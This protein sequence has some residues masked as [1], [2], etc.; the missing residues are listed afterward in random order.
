VDPPSRFAK[1]QGAGNRDW[2][3]EEL[4]FPVPDG[5]RVKQLY[6]TAN[7]ASNDGDVF[8][9]AL[10]ARADQAWTT[11]GNLFLVRERIYGANGQPYMQG[12][13]GEQKISFFLDNSDLPWIGIEAELETDPA[14]IEQWR[15]DTWSALYNAAQTAYYAEQQDIA[16]KIAALEDRLA[17]VDTLTLRRE[18]SE[19]V[20]KGVLKFI[21]GPSFDLMEPVVQFMFE[22][23]GLDAKHG[24]VF[25]GSKLPLVQGIGGGTVDP[26]FAF[27][28]IRHHEEMVRF[29]NQAIEWENVVTFLYSYFWDI[30]DSW[31][32]IRQLRHV[33]ATRQAFL[34]AGS[35][36]VVLTVRKGWEDKWMTFVQSGIIDADLAVPSTGPYLSIAQEIAA[37]DDRNYPGIP[38]ANPAR[39]AERLQDANYTISSAKINPGAGPITVPVEDSS[40]FKVGLKVVLDLE[41]DRHVQ[42]ASTVTA[43]PDKN[44]IIVDGLVHAH[45]GTQQAFPVVQPGEKG[46]LIAEWNEYTPSSGIDIAV[47]SNLTTIA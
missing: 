15:S 25:D 34:R 10:G 44:H 40:K 30:P 18:E 37:Y 2:L 41:D 42:E 17:N 22:A 39:A 11:P 45:D 5:A 16:G 8:L 3:Y 1:V 38:P 6:V 33:D 13:T 14:V 26:S 21:M 31:P 43:I 36:R 20:M 7:I 46:I 19:E 24:N 23:T 4:T 27:Q 35:A 32:F 47:T 28:T 29:I 12:A 9:R